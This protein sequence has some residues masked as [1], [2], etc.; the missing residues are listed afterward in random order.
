MRVS[1]WRYWLNAYPKISDTPRKQNQ[2]DQPSSSQSIDN[3]EVMGNQSHRVPKGNPTPSKVQF[4]GQK[5]NEPSALTQQ[6]C[7]KLSVTL[8]QEHCRTIVVGSQ[9]SLQN[10]GVMRSGSH[11]KG[12]PSSSGSMLYTAKG[13]PKL[14]RRQS[15]A[16]RRQPPEWPAQVGKTPPTLVPNRRDSKCCSN[17]SSGSEV[18]QQELVPGATCRSARH[19]RVMPQHSWEGAARLCK[20]WRRLSWDSWGYKWKITLWFYI[21]SYISR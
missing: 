4:S 7:W 5:E 6:S 17:L 10:D 1:H 15:H 12:K 18:P 14:S 8:L 9:W 13:N 16:H 3:T 21:C 11:I 20:A 19:C 2:C